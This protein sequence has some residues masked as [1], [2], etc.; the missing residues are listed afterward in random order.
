MPKFSVTVTSLCLQGLQYKNWWMEA[1]SVEI[2]KRDINFSANVS[3]GIIL[4]ICKRVLADQCLCTIL[5]TG[6]DNEQTWMVIIRYISG[7]NREDNVRNIYTQKG[8]DIHYTNERIQSHKIVGMAMS[9]DRL[10]YNAVCYLFLYGVFNDN[11]FISDH[12]VS[13][14]TIINA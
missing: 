2:K 11:V 13:N 10:R 5:K 1:F 9:R 12:T 3:K 14:D 7:H 8:L 4:V 6:V